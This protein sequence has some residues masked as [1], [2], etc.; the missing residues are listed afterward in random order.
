M[1]IK[2][3]MKQG[4]DN[5]RKNKERRILYFFVLGEYPIKRI[6]TNIQMII[7]TATQA[8][9]IEII[10]DLVFKVLTPE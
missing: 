2:N 7:T 5:K 6:E 9:K 10:L 1:L 8:E 3:N 4:Y